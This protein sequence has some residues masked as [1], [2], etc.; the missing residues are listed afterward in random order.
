MRKHWNPLVDTNERIIGVENFKNVRNVFKTAKYEV[1]T[2]RHALSAADIYD[3]IG[4][5]LDKCPFIIERQDIRIDPTP[6]QEE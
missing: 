2:T 6:V 4:V 5:Y 3:F 1:Y